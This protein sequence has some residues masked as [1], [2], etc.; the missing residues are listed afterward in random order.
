MLPEC[1]LSKVTDM[2]QSH[3]ALDAGLY[4]DKKLAMEIVLNDADVLLGRGT[5]HQLHPGNIVY[6]GRI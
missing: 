5:K 4:H 1:K 6:N 3:V 2:S